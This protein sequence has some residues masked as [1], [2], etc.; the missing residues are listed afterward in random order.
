[1]RFVVTALFLFV[2]VFTWA[3]DAQSTDVARGTVAGPGYTVT[4]PPDVEVDIRPTLDLAFGL[5]LSEATH[6]REWGHVPP[7]Y[8]GFS[9]E[10]NSEAGSLDEAVRHLTDDLHSL[11]PTE[12][13][14]DGEIRLASTFPAKL[15][16][17]PARRLVVEFRSR[18]HKPSIRQIVVAYRARPDATPVLYLATLTTTRTD[19]QQDV[20]LFAKL[21]AGFKLT[22]IQ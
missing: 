15:G 4:L 6:G 3:Q 12:L 16:D 13:V 11:V 17:L 21:L 9:T 2:S 7:R 1:M 19:F 5:D 10:W 22:P 14:S 18:Q 20:M 8:I